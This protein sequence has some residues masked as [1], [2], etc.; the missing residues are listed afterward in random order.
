MLGREYT[1]GSDPELFVFNQKT[2]KV[3]SAIDKIPGHKEEPYTEGLPQGYG[4]QTDNILAE[5]NIPPVTNERDF[6]KELEYMKE[7]IRSRVKEINEDL[8]ILCQA[9]AKVPAKE[10]KHP[11]AKEFGCDPDF[12]IYTKGPNEVSKASRTNLRSAGF[13]IH[14]GYPENNIDTSL[15]MLRYIDA[16]VGIP[17][18]LFDTDVDRRNLYGKAGC[19]RL[20]PYGFEYRTLSSYWLGNESRLKF[21]WRQVEHALYMYENYSPI[22]E[23][24]TTRDVINSNNTET[25]I[26]LIKKYN[27]LN[28][29]NQKPE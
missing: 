13:H 7:F 27:L 15:D 14:I 11:Q 3:V 8:D 1:I 22:P 21:I 5:F 9:S 20:Q 2:K 19:F 29:N 25:A 26:M 18:I 10:L 16:V 4:L 24:A 28:P 6:I 12:C 23:G 17:S